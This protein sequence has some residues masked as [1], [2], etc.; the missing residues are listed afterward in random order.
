MAAAVVAMSVLTARAPART[1]QTVSDG[2]WSDPSIWVD[3]LTGEHTLPTKD[4]IVVIRAHTILMT[5]EEEV[6]G[7]HLEGGTLDLGSFRLTAAGSGE[8]GDGV[9][10]G[11]GGFFNLGQ[12]SLAENRTKTLQGF[13]NNLARVIHAEEGSLHLAFNSVW[14]NEPEAVYVLES[15][16]NITG[17]ARWDAS[18]RFVNRGVFRK[19]A[20]SATSSVE[21]AFRNE[22]GIIEV[23]SGTLNLRGT[24]G[25]GSES[26]NGVFT[27]GAGATLDIGGG[28]VHVFNGLYRGGGEGTIRFSQGTIRVG[29]DLNDT[30]FRFEGNGFS[31]LGGSLDPMSGA[32]VNEGMFVLEGA[33]VKN[34]AEGPGFRNRGTVVQKDLGN[35]NL[36]YGTAWENMK[37]SVYDVS[38]DGGVVASGGKG[39]SPFFQNDGSFRKVNGTGISSIRTEFRNCGEIEIRAGLLNFTDA[40]VQ[41][42]GVTRLN[43]GDIAASAPLQILEGQLTGSGTV[44]ASV[45]ISGSLAPGSSP[46]L[47]RIHGNY[48]QGESG[49]MEIEIAGP[50]AGVSHDQVDIWGSAFLAGTLRVTLMN[51]Y[52]PSAG[53]R[54]RFLTS[55]GLYGRFG[56]LSLPPLPRGLNWQVEYDPQ[57]AHLAVVAE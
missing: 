36:E 8:W 2:S 41:T 33:S 49:A 44:F 7:F 50:E 39:A 21:V 47:M 53:D 27:V 52:S 11:S 32:M 51:G 16:A 18:P 6:A 40:F 19:A 42:G 46:G 14:V 22:D 5:G 55:R 1:L 17:L 12:M 37:T 54:F 31:W 24:P 57:N 34:L 48:A 25:T 29:T 3:Q 35:L 10:T 26:S 15:D 30:I 28:N 23:E 45:D 20:G 4:D 43:G 9:I 38:G 56:E 13:F